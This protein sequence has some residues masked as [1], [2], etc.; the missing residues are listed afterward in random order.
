MEEL[1]IRLK[2]VGEQAARNMK[3]I[4][5]STELPP[6]Y[7][8]AVLTEIPNQLRLLPLDRALMAL[9]RF[10]DWIP[11]YAEVRASAEANAKDFPLQ[12]FF[13][14]V[15][16]SE[17]NP[18]LRI[19]TPEDKLDYAAIQSIKLAYRL[20]A[21]LRLPPIIALLR[22]K[23][24]D[25]DTFC[26][27]LSRSNLFSER[28]LKLIRHGLTRHLEGDYV[29]GLHILTLQAEGL[30]RD[31]ARMLGLPVTAK[32]RGERMQERH[33][34]DLLDEAG[35]VDG[36]EA[37]FVALFKTLLVD[38]RGDNL[39]HGV[40]HALLEWEEFEEWK[41]NLMLMVL[42]NLSGYELRNQGSATGNAGT[43][44]ESSASS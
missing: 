38:I 2:E 10:R 30:I 40:A 23:G 22:E 26:A 33:L 6:E 44:A 41:C 14:I 36:L 3:P 39:R 13:P 17:G 31:L 35:I 27:H 21:Q 7:M 9:A 42:L 8:E 20:F 25:P 32:A 12:H 1:K 28:R 19:E 4:S 34:Q 5:V 29:S 15:L 43:A 16:I 24:M 18:V 37:D 11:R